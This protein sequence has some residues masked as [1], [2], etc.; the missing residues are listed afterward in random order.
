MASEREGPV[1]V[2]I[3]HSGDGGRRIRLSSEP[4][5]VRILVILVDLMFKVSFDD[6]SL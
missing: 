2:E 5:E 6:D 4:I 3:T 1:L